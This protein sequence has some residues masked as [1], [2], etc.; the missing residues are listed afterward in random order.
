L[1][2]NLHTFKELQS[3]STVPAVGTQEWKNDLERVKK[4]NR[5]KQDGL[6]GDFDDS[7]VAPAERFDETKA[8]DGIRLAK[9]SY[10]TSDLMGRGFDAKRAGHTQVDLRLRYEM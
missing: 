4:M 6:Y 5:L 1:R 8:A 3:P 7:G 9:I 2:S 10:N